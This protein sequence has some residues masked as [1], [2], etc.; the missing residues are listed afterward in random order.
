MQIIPATPSDE[1]GVKALLRSC[2][3]PFEDLT[4]AH[5][6]HFLVIKDYAQI[7]GVV[8]LEVCGAFGLLRSLAVAESL[9]GQRLGLQL[10]EQIEAYARSQQISVLYL[11]TTTAERFFAEFEYQEISRGSA[12]APL[13]ETTEFQSIC[14]DSAV[15]M[16]K[17]L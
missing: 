2:V 10:V 13:Q 15:C 5:L 9:R 16:C 6:A 1:A 8:G 3:L 7:V 12:P 11:L 14:P 17:N 4:P